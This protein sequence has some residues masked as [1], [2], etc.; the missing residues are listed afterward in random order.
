[1][2]LQQ[3][4]QRSVAKGAA[5]RRTMVPQCVMRA[6]SRS[7]VAVA[8]AAGSRS[9]SAVSSR[10]LSVQ[11][12]AQAAATAVEAQATGLSIDLRGESD[13]SALPPWRRTCSA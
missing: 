7:A 12:A 5:A 11:V 8:K 6:G 13:G 2:Q 10:G 3:A 1:M 9:R 4:T